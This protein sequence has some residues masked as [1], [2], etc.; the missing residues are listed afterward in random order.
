[1]DW[2][3]WL[4][5]LEGSA[6]A[7]SLRA[8]PWLYPAVETV[9]IA[10][11]ALLVGAIAVFDLRTLGLGRG[12]PAEALARLA[13]PLAAAGLA[14]AALSGTALFITDAG[15]LA[16][17]PAFLLKML[18]FAAGLANAAFWHAAARRRPG[19]AR[20]SAA[21]SLAVWITVLTLGRLIAYV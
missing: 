18:A 11:F 5:A 9:H 6:A 20:L 14:A 3:D 19:A 2:A 16:G 13:V 7:A 1:V 17:N 10:G 8:S 4:G 12:I 21:A 15:D